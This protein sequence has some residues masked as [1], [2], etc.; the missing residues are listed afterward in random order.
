MPNLKPKEIAAKEIN[1]PYKISWSRLGKF[2]TPPI[3]IILSIALWFVHIYIP[4]NI[5]L[6]NKDTFIP[7]LKTTKTSE[8]KS[9]VINISKLLSNPKNYSGKEL[10]VRGYYYQDFESSALLDSY[11]YPE[12]KIGNYSTWVVNETG[13]DIITEST[14]SEAVRDVVACGLFETGENYGLI[15]SY[16]N[17]LTLKSFTP[18]G[19]AIFL[20]TLD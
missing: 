5:S 14:G 8:E 9:N 4:S 2:V 3:L 12:K 1:S 20:N 17:Q 18:K 10:C 6:Q 15:R 11:N 16:Q 19:E 7:E 13:R